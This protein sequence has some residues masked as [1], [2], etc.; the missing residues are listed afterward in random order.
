MK[1]NIQFQNDP[2]CCPDGPGAADGARRTVRAAG[3]QEFGVRR[4]IGRLA[5]QA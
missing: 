3:A 2:G 1:T 5:S 4:S